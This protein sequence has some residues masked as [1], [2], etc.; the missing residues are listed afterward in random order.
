VHVMNLGTDS[1]GTARALVTP[2]KGYTTM[3]GV[4]LPARMA[5]SRRIFVR[6]VSFPRRKIVTQDR[7]EP[8]DLGQKALS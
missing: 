7:L 5:L 6:T 2:P 1:Y 8:L 4:Y 3:S